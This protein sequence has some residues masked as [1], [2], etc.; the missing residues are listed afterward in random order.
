[1]VVRRIFYATPHA[2]S[3]IDSKMMIGQ[4]FHILFNSIK[5]YFFLDFFERRWEMQA[6]DSRDP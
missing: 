4:S 1:M 3:L 5:F 6:T 2:Q